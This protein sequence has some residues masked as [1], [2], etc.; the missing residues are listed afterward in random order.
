MARDFI[1][2]HVYV[3]D[4]VQF[5]QERDKATADGTTAPVY[6]VTRVHVQTDYWGFCDVSLKGLP[7]TYT[8]RALVKVQ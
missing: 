5:W 4:R 6:E 7:D 2:R 3:G 8:L 1:G